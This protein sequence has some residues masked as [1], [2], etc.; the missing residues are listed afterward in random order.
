MILSMFGK[1]IL[2][3]AGT[4]VIG[5]SL[6]NEL[7][8]QGA[9][10]YTTTRKE[11]VSDD[12]SLYIKGD[13]HSDSFV[14]NIILQYEIDAVVDFVIYETNKFS[15]RVKWILDKK[16]Q[17]IFISSYRVF[18]ESKKPITESS[19][20]LK[21][22]IS[23]EEYLSS[24]EYALKKTDQ[25]RILNKYTQYCWTI[26]RPSITYGENRL[27]LG[28][29]ESD[30]ILPRISNDLEIPLPREILDKK[31]TMTLGGDVAKMLSKLLFNKLAY[32][33]DYNVLSS[34][35]HTW[36]F[37]SDIY[38]KELNLKVRE[39]PLSNF[40]E[41]EGNRWQIKYDRMYNR[42]CDNSKVLNDTKLT[43]KDMTSLSDGLSNILNEIVLSKYKDIN[44]TLSRKNGHIDRVLSLKRIPLTLNVKKVVLYFIG[45]NK[46]L[47]ILYNKIS[48]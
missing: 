1:K 36:R 5:N 18:A 48:K 14:R 17:Y 35:N 30:L 25:E 27:Q 45:R 44:N 28:S 39:V 8:S 7:I 24:D 21:D 4:G 37:I 46:I 2:L 47:D 9:I 40:M 3:L 41:I 22:V 23:D 26:A 29:F 11:R 15:E 42:I 32:N 31:T 38:R 34:E 13:A 6:K 33:N 12:S 19:P 16:R 10:V 20:F 43:V